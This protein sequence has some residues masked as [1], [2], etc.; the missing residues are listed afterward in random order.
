MS[1]RIT[2]VEQIVHSQDNP[3]RLIENGYKAA[4]WQA[5][6]RFGIDDCGHSDRVEG[7][8]RSSCSIELKLKETRASGGM[9]GWS[10]VAIFEAWCECHD[11]EDEDDD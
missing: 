1:K 6:H 9:G 8:A 7:W 5:L 11:D 3:A 4:Q 10:Y 2:E